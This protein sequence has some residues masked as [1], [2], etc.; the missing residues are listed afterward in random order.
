[1]GIVYTPADYDSHR[2]PDQDGLTKARKTLHEGLTELVD[3]EII[4]GANIH[5]SNET[6]YDKILCRWYCWK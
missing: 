6:K 3:R 5:G 2:I 4:F 1:M